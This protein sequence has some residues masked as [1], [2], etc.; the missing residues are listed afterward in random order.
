MADDPR[1]AQVNKI[2]HKNNAL[3]ATAER[4]R[5][6]AQAISDAEGGTAKFTIRK[7]IRPG[8]RAFVDVVSDNPAEEF[9]TEKVKK[10]GAL[11]RAARGG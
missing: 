8:G 2:V 5:R 1:F 6:R 9:G 3:L 10:I 4:V 11:R 7:G